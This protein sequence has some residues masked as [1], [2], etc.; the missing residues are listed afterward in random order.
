MLLL[1]YCNYQHTQNEQ[2]RHI[3]QPKTKYKMKMR[4]RKMWKKIP[5]RKIAKTIYARTSVAA[6]RAAQLANQG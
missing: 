2:M 6:M 1:L 4:T 3:Y 5:M